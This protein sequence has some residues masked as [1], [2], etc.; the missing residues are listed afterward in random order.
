MIDF[1]AKV[2]AMS[3]L[4]RSRTVRLNRGSNGFVE[5]SKRAT[6]IRATLFD[7]GKQSDFHDYPDF[8]SAFEMR[9][10]DFAL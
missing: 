4:I 6:S 7:L 3:C 10:S 8:I 5:A 1:S 2:K 9:I